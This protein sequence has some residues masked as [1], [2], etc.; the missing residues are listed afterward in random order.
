VHAVLSPCQHSSLENS[1]KTAAV[2]QY[3]PFR[4]T[5]TYLT[6]NQHHHG[7]YLCMAINN[8]LGTPE[9]KFPSLLTQSC[10]P[11]SRLRARLSHETTRCPDAMPLGQKLEG[12]TYKEVL[13]S[14][15]LLR[16]W[17]LSLMR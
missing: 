12:L 7:G 2:P 8:S 16:S 14:T 4:N 13:T 10:D 11:D 17:Q 6:T 5:R 15:K 3:P 1:W 9:A